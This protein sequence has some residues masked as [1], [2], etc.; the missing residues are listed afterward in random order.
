[1]KASL[2]LTLTLAVALGLGMARPALTQDF[3]SWNCTKVA[4]NLTEVVADLH[5]APYDTF[6]RVVSTSD[7]GLPS[8]GTAIL[9]SVRPGSAPGTLGAKANRWMVLNPLDH[10]YATDEVVLTPIPNTP[11]VNDVVTISIRGG[12]GKYER[13]SGQIVA[14]GRGFNFFPG[15]VAGKTYFAFSYTG[16][17]CVP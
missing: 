5:A 16:E 13:A 15:P 12:Q 4:G 3:K 8:V 11:D 6:G 1:M 14:T 10:I 2:S 7:G 9:T 17:V